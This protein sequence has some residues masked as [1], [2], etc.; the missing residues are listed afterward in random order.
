MPADYEVSHASA[1]P[2]TWFRSE[3]EIV[4]V[5]MKDRKDHLGK[6]VVFMIR[7]PDRRITAECNARWVTDNNEDI[8]SKTAATENCKS[9]SIGHVMLERSD[10]KHS[11]LLFR[12]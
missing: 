7:Q 3:F 8:P 10:W 9:L 6:D 5:E 4:A 2:N 1:K 11:L 12:C